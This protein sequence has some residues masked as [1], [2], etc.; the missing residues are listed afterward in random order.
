MHKQ[1]FTSDG[2]DVA[3]VM[4]F[5]FYNVTLVVPIGKH[6][7]GTKFSSIGIDYEAGRLEIYDCHDSTPD[8]IHS[9]K[10]SVDNIQSPAA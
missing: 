7:V 2:C 3:D 6:P 9:L 1:L 10:L 5:I 4:C 8:E